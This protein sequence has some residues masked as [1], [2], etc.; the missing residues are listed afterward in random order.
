[1]LIA[2]CIL[3]FILLWGYGLYALPLVFSKKSNAQALSSLE[4]WP[5][6]SFVIP[7]FNE[8]DYLAE[9]IRNTLSLDYPADK[10]QIVVAADGSDDESESV[11][12]QF[13]VVYLN[14]GCRDG[15]ANAMNRCIEHC[16]GEVIVF[17]DANVVVNTEGLKALVTTL[18]SQDNV[19]LVSG[20]KKVVKAHE[21]HN[22]G[23]G[24]GVYW[25]YETALKKI[26]SEYFSLIGSVG[27]LFAVKKERY[28][29]I[30]SH[31]LLDDF[32]ISVELLRQG[33]TVKY[34]SSALAS[35]YGSSDYKE[36]AKRKIRIAAG[37]WQCMKHFSTLLNP[38][39]AFK[40]SYLYVSHRV[41]RQSIIPFSL[42]VFM[43]VLL[44]LMQV[45]SPNWFITINLTGFVFLFALGAIGWYFNAKAGD[46]KAPFVVNVTFYILFMNVC[47]IAGAFRYFKGIKSGAWEK[48]KRA[49]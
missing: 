32:Y 18:C 41:L 26:D 6:V 43:P 46:K 44:V 5:M 31:F 28:V 25:K 45:Y 21:A 10:L 11:S 3:L 42:I 30:P 22:A 47:A 36:E 23:A 12:K 38:F 24:E 17:S 29:S 7:A 4:H 14:N 19:A 1:M 39:V 34:V 37:A 15:K 35:E 9:K 33:Y 8:A 27:E 20:E 48:S 40:A 16:T 13:N 49:K 2:Y